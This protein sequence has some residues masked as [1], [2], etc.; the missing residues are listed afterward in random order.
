M[1]ASFTIWGRKLIMLDAFMFRKCTREVWMLIGDW[2]IPEHV[3]YTD[4]HVV[5]PGTFILVSKRNA[6]KCHS[7][8]DLWAIFVPL[9]EFAIC[10]PRDI[11]KIV[12]LYVSRNNRH[13][14]ERSMTN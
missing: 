1:T 5:G 9:K 2:R 3:G 11:L 14:Q 7:Y 12:K 13:D 4:G 8:H 10:F 6:G